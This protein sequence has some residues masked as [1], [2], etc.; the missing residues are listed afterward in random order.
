MTEEAVQLSV[1]ETVLMT[2]LAKVGRQEIQKLWPDNF[3]Q[4]MLWKQQLKKC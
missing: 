1:E 2:E 4:R 3:P